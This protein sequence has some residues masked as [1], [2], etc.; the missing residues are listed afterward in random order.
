MPKGSLLIL[1]KGPGAVNV[2]VPGPWWPLGALG[3]PWGP[4]GALGV[5]CGPLGSLG[6][7][8][9]GLALLCF[10]LRYVVCFVLHVLF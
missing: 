8:W 1:C 4:L 5:P 2:T 7:A 10:A 9:V 3:G 6:V